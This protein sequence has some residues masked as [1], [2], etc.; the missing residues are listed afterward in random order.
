M[1]NCYAFCK[2]GANLMAHSPLETSSQVELSISCSNLKKVGYFI[3]ND[4]AV[5]LYYKGHGQTDWTKLGRTEVMDNTLNPKVYG[6][7]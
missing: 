1:V 7:D 4:S 3:K 5:F 2:F 6:I